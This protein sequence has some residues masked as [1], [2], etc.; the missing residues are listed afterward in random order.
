M[1]SITPFFPLA[2]P[3]LACYPTVTHSRQWLIGLLLMA[4]I[5]GLAAQQTSTLTVP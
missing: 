2:R 3:K 1:F 5:P 4:V